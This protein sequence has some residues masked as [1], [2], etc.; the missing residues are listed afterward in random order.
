VRTIT[1][2]ATS[3]TAFVGRARRGPVDDPKVINSYGD[4]ERIFG[5]LW[6]DSS[7]SFAVR[8][9]YLN[10]GSRAVIVR[11]Y[12]PDPGNP[13][14]SPPVPA[15]PT[16]AK[17]SVGEINLLAAHHGKWGSN[18]R[19]SVDTNVSADAAL[20]MNLTKADLFNLTV[21]DTGSGG[22]TEQ[23]RNLTV[24]DSPRR[25]DNVL[26]EES[27]LVRWD[28]TWPP[29]SLP[30]IA[31]GDDAITAVEKELKA[32]QEE[33]KTAQALTPPDPAKVA[34]AQAK[35]TA[36]EGK[37]ASATKATESSDG[38]ALTS[39]DFIGTGKEDAK[40]GL[41]G[42]EKTDLFNLLCI[43]PYLATNDI[44]PSLVTAAATYCEKRRAM[45]IIDSSSTWNTKDKAKE[46][47]GGVGTTSKNSALFFPRLKQPNPL[48]RFGRRICPNRYRARGVEGA[49]RA[50]GD[51]P[52]ST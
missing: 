27:K 50:G 3:I 12:H 47:I 28:G 43:P 22:T 26:R 21:K 38:I 2:V 13:S 17:L 19:A 46:N 37:L 11:L 10:G 41:Y 49:R 45:L 1:G 52:G 42:L 32:A 15:P 25:I 5:G 6:L 39:D 51:A 29:S 31:A 33:L 35:V 34:A 20:H 14:A 9:F 4:F 44:D 16:K 23:F 40:E 24:K 18:L 30:A 8:D 48:R 7:M 36:A